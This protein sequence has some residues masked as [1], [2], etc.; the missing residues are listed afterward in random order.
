M[1][2]AWTLGT[3][4]HKEAL[5]L[6]SLLLA[7]LL[8]A[9]AL[10]MGKKDKALESMEPWAQVGAEVRKGV[11]K[12]VMRTPESLIDEDFIN[13]GMPAEPHLE[14]GFLPPNRLIHSNSSEAFAFDN[15]PL[16]GSKALKRCGRGTA[17]ASFWCYIDPPTTQS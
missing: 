11:G 7:A 6:G 5:T 1:L 9:V 16:S 13:M 2:T 12:D 10:Q 4:G 3:S 15:E 14:G 17:V 8:G